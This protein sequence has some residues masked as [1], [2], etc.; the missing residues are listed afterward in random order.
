MKNHKIAT[1]VTEL[2]HKKRY[3]RV[4]LRSLNGERPEQCDMCD[5][6]FRCTKDLA[7]HLRSHPGKKHT[8]PEWYVYLR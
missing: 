7:F 2:S 5:E 3:L 4:H 6:A 1:S 8:K